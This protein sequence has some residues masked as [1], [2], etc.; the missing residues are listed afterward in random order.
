VTDSATQLVEKI[1]GADPKSRS[2]WTSAL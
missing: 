2:A 1:L